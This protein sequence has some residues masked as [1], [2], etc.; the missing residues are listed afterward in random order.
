MAFIPGQR[1]YSSTEPELG[2]GT[3]LRL[4]G[5]QVQLVFTGS[6][7]LRHYA[8]GTAPLLRVAFRPGDRVRVSGVEL[9]IE[10]A[11]ETDG[12]IHYR[13][14][15]QSFF[16]GELDAEQPVSQADTRLLAGHVDRND[17]FEF[18]RECLMRSAE[19]RAHAGWGILGARIDLIPHQLRVA[20]IAVKRRPPRLLL[21]DEV[22]L[23]KTIEACLIVA[24]MLASG[25]ASRVCV[26]LPESLVNQWF[27]ELLRRFNLS[28]A[29]YDEER[30]EA[31]ELNN[32]GHNPFDD[33]QCII[34][35]VDW[36]SS[37]GKRA[38]QCL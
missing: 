15:N 5:R 24:Q 9:I 17:Q 18:R 30:C 13:A 23:G 2:L 35:S 4:S 26:L 21:A 34:A 27:V 14:S 6:G 32:S 20:E 3:V 31:I 7:M 19:A 22:G 16:E 38:K 37:H 25:R 10:A 36:L 33:E 11:E 29:I 8:I 12:L 1:W 28:F